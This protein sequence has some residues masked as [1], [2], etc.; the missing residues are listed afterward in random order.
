[1]HRLVISSAEIVELLH[2]VREAETVKEA[3]QAIKGRVRG[4]KIAHGDET[5]WREEGGGT[6]WLRVELEYATG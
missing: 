1:M 5:G 6:E 3:V 2:R 4:S